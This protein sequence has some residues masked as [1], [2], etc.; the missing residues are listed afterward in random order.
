VRTFV[1][2]LAGWFGVVDALVCMGGYNTLG[3]ALVRGTPTVC[4]PR[5]TP[6]SEQ[7]IRARALARLGLLEVVEPDSLDAT[8]L[9]AAIGRT[10][11]RT[12]PSLA[13]AANKALPFDGAAIAADNLLAKAALSRAGRAGRN[14]GRGTLRAVSAPS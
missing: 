5:T 8:A 1:P 13:R 14:G 10:L 11:R 3:E 4:V 7:L 9:S 12:R 6:R 2:E